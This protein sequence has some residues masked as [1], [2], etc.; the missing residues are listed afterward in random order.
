MFEHAIRELQAGRRA[1]INPKGNSMTP[2]IRSGDTVRLRPCDFEEAAVGD[3]VL[4][5]VR[6]IL[7]LHRVKAKDARSGRVLIGSDRGS[8][9]GWT[10]T[11]YGKVVRVG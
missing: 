11:V 1:T 9:N 5:K 6:G 7:Y 2:A 10:K 3:V 4:C 8:T